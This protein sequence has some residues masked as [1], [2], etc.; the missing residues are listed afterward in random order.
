MTISGEDLDALREIIN[1]GVGRAAASLNEMLDREVR[2]NVPSVRVAM[3]EEVESALGAAAG[4]QVACV[5]VRFGGG[6][7][8][9]ADLL[10]PSVAASKLVALLMGEDE[11]PEDLDGLRAGA[12]TEVGNVLLNSL[13][14]S[15]TNL[16]GEH[17]DY[18]LPAY[19][20]ESTQQVESSLRG[21][22]NAAVLLA[23][24]QFF[25]DSTGPEGVDERIDGE[26][27]L[28]LEVDS[29]ERLVARL[30]RLGEEVL[31]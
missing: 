24:A 21:A 20:E 18:D 12:L 17:I 9:S 3:P 6:L 26:V 15:I 19:S 10:F 25:V 16:A 30:Q 1:I 5:R 22:H 28:L 14:G 2:L 11:Y 27:T 13:M 29:L 4:A 8:G 31:T 23:R 7:S